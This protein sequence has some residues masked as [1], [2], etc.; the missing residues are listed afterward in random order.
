MASSA[1]THE[2]PSWTERGRKMP[3]PMAVRTMWLE[4]RPVQ[5]EASRDSTSV[6]LAAIKSPEIRF[7]LLWIQGTYHCIKYTSCVTVKARVAEMRIIPSDL[8]A[9][10][11]RW[12]MFIRLH[13]GG[14]DCRCYRLPSASPFLV[15]LHVLVG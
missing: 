1:I 7:K 4:P 12:Q 8:L 15:C 10:L 5:S 13:H 14:G 3:V 11:C 2:L 6:W 9:V